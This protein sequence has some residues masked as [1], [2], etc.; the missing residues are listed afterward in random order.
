MSSDEHKNVEEI[1]DTFLKLSDKLIPDDAYELAGRCALYGIEEHGTGFFDHEDVFGT[2]T[3]KLT[4]YC[5]KITAVTGAGCCSLTLEVE[6]LGT[7]QQI[8]DHR[9]KTGR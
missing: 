7:A 9:S 8:I 1:C 3:Y 4:R 5:E 2:D 6:L